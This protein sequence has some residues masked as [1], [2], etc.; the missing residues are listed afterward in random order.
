M[1]KEFECYIYDNSTDDYWYDV[2]LDECERILDSFSDE[3][4]AELSEK[5][6]D[7]SEKAQMRCVECLSDIDNRNSLSIILKL[8]HTN[9]R[10]LFVTCVDSLR[11]MDISSLFQSEKERLSQRVKAYSANA[12]SPENA[13]FKAFLNAVGH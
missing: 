3:E 11:N 12:S 10:E 6:G 4:W 13:V 2:A 7:Y 8:S 1:L 5:I 9:N